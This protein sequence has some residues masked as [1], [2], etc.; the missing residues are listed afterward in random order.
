MSGTERGE[1]QVSQTYSISKNEW[2]AFVWVC[3]RQPCLR[4]LHKSVHDEHNRAA[5]LAI[6]LF[7]V[8]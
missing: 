2:K 1:Y 3:S 6:G 5:G 7:V 4:A 8:I